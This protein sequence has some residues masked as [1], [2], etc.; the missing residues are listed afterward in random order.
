MNKIYGIITIFALA[1][2]MMPTSAMQVEATSDLDYMLNIAEKAKRYIK[3]NIDEMENSNTQDWKNRQAVLE[4][5]NKSTYEIDQ[6]STAIKDGDVKSAREHFISS[7]SKIKQISQMLNQIAENKAQDAALPDHS[8]IIKR[9]EMNYQRLQQISDKIGADVDFSEMKSLISLAKQNN[10]QGESDKAK[11]TIDKIALKGL[12]IYKSLQSI[13]E[14]NK[15]IRAQALAEKYVDRINTLIVQA[16]TSGLLDYVNMLENSKIQLISSN[17]TSQITKQ[18]RIVITIHNDIEEI[19]KNN[20][21]QIDVD[22]I[23]LSQ[24]QRITSELA[25]FE[26]RAK[27]LHSDVKGSNAALYYVEKAISVIDNVRNNLDDSIQ[28]INSKLQLIE[29]LLTKAEKLVQEST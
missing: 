14:K 5:Y 26:T 20:L 18:I 12:E 8:Q 22:Q 4:I 25:Q 2:L 15:I 21:Q 16:K 10:Q 29:Q 23:Q 27:L 11:Q 13:N 7:M 24:K 1:G 28:K 19:K 6:L 17:S 9:Y 3:H